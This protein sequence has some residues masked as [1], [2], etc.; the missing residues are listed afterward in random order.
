MVNLTIEVFPTANYVKEASIL[1]EFW[2]TI[3]DKKVSYIKKK[4]TKK[5]DYEYIDNIG[6]QM[7]L[8]NAQL[9][10]WDLVS[11]SEFWRE[12]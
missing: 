12:K 11:E 4:K 9:W 7:F 1:V 2:V 6:I 5:S 8:A 3:I 10:V